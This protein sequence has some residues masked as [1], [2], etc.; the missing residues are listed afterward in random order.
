NVVGISHIQFV[1]PAPWWGS[2]GAPIEIKLSGNDWEL[3]NDIADE[4]VYK[5]SDV[6][7]LF[8]VQKNIREDIPVY[9][10]EFDEEKIAQFGLSYAEVAGRLRTLVHGGVTWDLR[11]EFR[12]NS[13]FRDNNVYIISRLKHSDRTELEDILELEMPTSSGVSIPIKTFVDVKK[14]Y[15]TNFIT[16]ENK[17][18]RIIVSAQTSDEPLNTLIFGKT[19]PVLNRVELPAGINMEVQGEVTRMNNQVS[20]MMIGFIFAAIFVY[21]VLA[22]QFESLKQPFIMML[23]IPLQLIGVFVALYI[24]GNTLNTTSGNGIIALVGVVVNASIVLIDYINL[25]RSRGLTLREAIL[26]SGETRF[27]PIVMTVATTMFAMLP[28]ALSQAEGSDIYKPLA[29]AFI[30]GLISSSI[31]TLYIIPVL[32]SVFEGGKNE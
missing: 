4:Y 8:D 18:K 22:G 23:S 6:A 13:L 15:E 2:A 30:G 17:V 16:K 32:Y 24:T 25:L 5:L 28:M 19:L 7:G 27:R 31:M 11:T 29:I 3:L 21:M 20:G 9:K 12:D 14:D 1:Q 26:T 10:F